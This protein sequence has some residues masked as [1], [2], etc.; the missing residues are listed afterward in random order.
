MSKDIPR[1]KFFGKNSELTPEYDYNIDNLYQRMDTHLVPFE[2]VIARG[3][4]CMTCPK[5]IS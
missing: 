2:R 1:P 4:K 5:G 3:D